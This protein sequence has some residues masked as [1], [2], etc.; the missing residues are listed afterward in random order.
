MPDSAIRPRKE[1]GKTVAADITH[2]LREEII[3]AYYCYRCCAEA[4]DKVVF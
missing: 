4:L 1:F 3:A 2:R